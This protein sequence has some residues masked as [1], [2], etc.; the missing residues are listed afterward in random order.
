MLK[1]LALELQILYLLSSTL[2]SKC[3]YFLLHIS[4]EI[5]IVM[6]IPISA[7]ILISYLYQY[8]PNAY[9]VRY[10]T[11]WSSST[12]PI[13][14]V[15]TY[16]L[17]YCIQSN[18]WMTTFTRTSKIKFEN[19][20]VIITASY[21]PALFQKYCNVSKISD[22][23]LFEKVSIQKLLCTWCVEHYTI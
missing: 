3:S 7:P 19:N 22:S 10:T 14:F 13:I 11:S 21:I 5:Y 2:N 18:F 20:R 6:L 9:L 12:Y 16:T 4:I 23:Q 15:S 17:Q 1:Y 8:S